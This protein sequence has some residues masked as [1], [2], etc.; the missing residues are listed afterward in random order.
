MKCQEFRNRWARR[1]L[2]DS[3]VGSKESCELLRHRDECPA[4]Q[5]LAT[6]LDAVR[7]GLRTVHGST[8]PDAGFSARVLRRLESTPDDVELLGWAAWRVLPAAAVLLV[9][10]LAWGSSVGWAPTRLEILLLQEHPSQVA[11]EIL[12]AAEEER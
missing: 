3:T 2:A 12:L 8:Q 5:A 9:A 7:Q 4:C 1:E 6:R 11:V 10:L